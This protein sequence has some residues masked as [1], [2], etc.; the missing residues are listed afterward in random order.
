MNHQKSKKQHFQGKSYREVQI[1]NSKNRNK[2][3]KKDQD[4]LI[5]KDY[6]NI[7]WNNIINL[8][9]KIEEFLEKYSCEQLTIEELFLEADRIGN[10]Y[11]TNHEIEKFNQNLSQAVNEIAE[12]IDQQF[13]ETE[14]EFIDYSGKT[15]N[16]YR[17]K[18]NQKTYSTVKL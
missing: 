2:L 9:R 1:A 18:H 14:V 12:K 17:K 4:W 3:H 10:K 15:N 6:R 5:E 8:Y 16:R 7:G 13:P 11:M